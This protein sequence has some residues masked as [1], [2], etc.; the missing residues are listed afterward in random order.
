MISTI[1]QN[2]K[3]LLLKPHVLDVAYELYLEAPPASCSVLDLRILSKR[4][5]ASLLECRNAIVKVY[6]CGRFLQCAVET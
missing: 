6:R 5:G 1:A 4:T 2:I 3:P